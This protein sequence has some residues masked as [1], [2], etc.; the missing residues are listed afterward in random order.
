MPEID[1]AKFAELQNLD[2]FVRRGLANPKTRRKILEVQKTLNPETAVPELDESDP[3]HA[4]IDAIA[5]SFEKFKGELS[6]KE[7]ERAEQARL[8]ELQNKFAAGRAVAKKHGYAD[9]GLVKLEKFMEEDGIGN[10]EHAIPFFEKVNPPPVPATNSGTRWDF[11]GQQT[12]DGAD[13]KP[14]F[15]GHEEQWLNS[16]VADTLNRVRNSV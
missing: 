11:F 5:D 8:T 9:D 2:A 3:L 6:S 12:P 16:A 4:K 7:A 14:L 10:H 13:L 15:D 1:D